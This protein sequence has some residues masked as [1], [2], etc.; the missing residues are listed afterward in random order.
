MLKNLFAR[1]ND[2][3]ILISRHSCYKDD[4]LHVR[5]ARTDLVEL[6]SR[7]RAPRRM[8]GRSQQAFADF[9]HL[10]RSYFREIERGERNPTFSALCKICMGLSCDMAS[11]AK[12]NPP[13]LKTRRFLPVR[14]LRDGVRW[15]T[16]LPAKRFQSLGVSAMRPG[17][18]LFSPKS[19]Q[20]REVL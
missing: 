13:L 20:D 3:E 8:T 16:D 19:S 9:C 11:L 4:P 14:R 1:W 17:T 6:G 10:D 12:G 18:A 2:A 15:S 5:D 7:I